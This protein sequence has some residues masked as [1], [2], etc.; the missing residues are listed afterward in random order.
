MSVL[1]RTV[2]RPIVTE[3]SSAAFQARKEYAFMAD[4]LATKREI[5]AAIEGL[6]SVTVV[7][8]RTLQQ[9]SKRRTMG[10]RPGRK[11]RWKKA[12]VLL[13]EGDAIQGVFE[14]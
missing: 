1:H 11:P 14:G 12:Y 10:R 13:R 5:K 3:K 8:V 9:R 7:S 4:P 6:F 2:V